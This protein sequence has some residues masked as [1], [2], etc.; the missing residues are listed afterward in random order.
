[1]IDRRNTTIGFLL[2]SFVSSIGVKQAQSGEAERKSLAHKVRI[3]Q[4]A[5]SNNSV[6]L[7][8]AQGQ[9]FFAKYGLSRRGNNL[10]T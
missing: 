3:S 6:P 2:F 8:V 10:R 4:S 5:I 9:G 7:W 1:M